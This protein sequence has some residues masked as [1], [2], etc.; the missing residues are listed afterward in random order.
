M[1]D[2]DVTPRWVARLGALIIRPAARR[3]RHDLTDVGFDPAMLTEAQREAALTEQASGDFDALAAPTERAYATVFGHTAALAGAHGGVAVVRDVG[4]WFG[5][6]AYVADAR[7]D[8]AQD[9]AHER[10]NALAACFGTAA[11]PQG[12]ALADAAMERLREA[13]GRLRLL[14]HREVV[15]QLFSRGLRRKIAW[16]CGESEGGKRIRREKP[17]APER[18]AGRPRWRGWGCSGGWS[19]EEETQTVTCC[20]CGD[21]CAHCCL[22][23]PCACCS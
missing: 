1:R 4:R 23:A 3:A 19:E 18:P 8:Y 2:G 13:L 17:K 11:L 20:C 12:A 14:R 21:A 9:V 16:A 15:E 7:A 6:L 10:F 5:R 22:I